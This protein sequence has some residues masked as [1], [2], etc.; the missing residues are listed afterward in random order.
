MTQM[1]ADR[2][3]GNCKMVN[4]E[5]MTVEKGMDG[6]VILAPH[7]SRS[8]GLF[9]LSVHLR[10]SASSAVEVRFENRELL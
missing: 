7:L 3:S 10:T 1:S 5:E 2:M 8:S 4:R 9:S 6:K